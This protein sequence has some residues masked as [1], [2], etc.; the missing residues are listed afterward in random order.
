MFVK[1][2]LIIYNFTDAPPCC[3]AFLLTAM[4]STTTFPK[5]SP[6]SLLVLLEK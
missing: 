2:E 1:A 4:F 6:L 3:S 5:L